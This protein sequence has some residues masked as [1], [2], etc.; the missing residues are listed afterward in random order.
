[1]IR[2]SGGKSIGMMTDEEIGS[3]QHLKDLRYICN[4][5]RFSSSWINLKGE[6]PLK[7]SALFGKDIVIDI[8]DTID[9][10]WCFFDEKLR[11]T[12]KKYV[13]INYSLLPMIVFYKKEEIQKNSD[14]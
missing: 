7:F 14:V 6:N 4:M 12:A 13:D 10:K 5:E 11:E 1:M 9:G 3:D 8:K 2:L